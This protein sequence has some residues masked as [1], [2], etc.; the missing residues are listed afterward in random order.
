MGGGIIF[1]CYNC[2]DYVT[3]VTIVTIVL[4]LCKKNVKEQKLL[5]FCKKVVKF[6]FT[7]FHQKPMYQLKPKSQTHFF[8]KTFASIPSNGEDLYRIKKFKI[9]LTLNR[10]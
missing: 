1:L 8:I 3:I 10:K 4:Q 5:F 2:Y 6:V 7:D 9:T